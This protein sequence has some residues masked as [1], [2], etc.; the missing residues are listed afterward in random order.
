MGTALQLEEAGEVQVI[1]NAVIESLNARGWRYR[2]QDN[3]WIHMQVRGEHGLYDTYVYPNERTEVIS[4]VIR[5]S[6]LVPEDL[7]LVACEFL[8]RANCRMR[9]G[10]FQLDFDDGEVSYRAA[11]DVEGSTLAPKMVKSL[12]GSGLGAFDWYY[13][14]LMRVVYC[15]LSPAEAVRS[16]DP[17][18]DTAA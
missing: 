4:V 18:N 13:P 5:T 6:Y 1:R 3:G 9:F 2:V 15:L 8:N 14:G 10:N 16:L 7:R 12:I 11:I 17:R